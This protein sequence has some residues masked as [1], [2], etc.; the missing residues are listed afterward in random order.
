MCEEET[1]LGTRVDSLR[2]NLPL[3]RSGDAFQKFWGL[4]RNFKSAPR[5]YYFNQISAG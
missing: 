3:Y 5:N 4:V 2:L 1:S